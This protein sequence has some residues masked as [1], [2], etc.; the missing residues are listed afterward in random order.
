MII[1]F[2]QQGY[3]KT[4]FCRDPFWSSEAG[5]ELIFSFHNF[6]SIKPMAIKLR[7]LI[8]RQELFP[9]R[10]KKRMVQRTVR[11]DIKMA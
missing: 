7:R 3:F 4:P 11:H 8:L 5:G 10:A 2:D 9:L 1:A 6:N